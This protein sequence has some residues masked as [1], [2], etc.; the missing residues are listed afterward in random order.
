[1]TRLRA[2]RPYSRSR[3]GST[4]RG[5]GAGYVD[6][7]GSLVLVVIAAVLIRTPALRPR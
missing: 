4:V 6:I 2:A 1:M 7:N 3:R 5:P